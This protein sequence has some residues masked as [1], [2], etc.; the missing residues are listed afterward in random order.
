[1]HRFTNACNP[2]DPCFHWKRP[3]FEGVKAKIEDI[4]YM[5]CHKIA[6]GIDVSTPL[7]TSTSHENL[8]NWS[9]F[10]G[11]FIF[12]VVHESMPNSHITLPVGHI[13]PPLRWV[14]KIRAA[15]QEQ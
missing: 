13:R 7:K 5:I 10:G 3:S 1:M 11:H 9:F 2:N 4:H 15:S 12:G 14:E 6:A 8:F